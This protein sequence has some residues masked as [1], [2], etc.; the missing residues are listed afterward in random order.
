MRL[1]SERSQLLMRLSACREAT[2]SFSCTGDRSSADAAQPLTQA[3]HE[4]TLEPL[5]AGAM[6]PVCLAAVPPGPLPDM[7][8]CSTRSGALKVTFNCHSHAG[9]AAPT[10]WTGSETHPA[11]SA[12]TSPKAQLNPTHAQDHLQPPARAGAAA[13]GPWAASPRSTRQALTPSTQPDSTP[14]MRR[15]TFTLRAGAAASEPWTASDS[16]RFPSASPSPQFTPHAEL[17]SHAQDHLQPAVRARSAKAEPWA[18]THP[19]GPAAQPALAHPQP[20]QRARPGS[21]W[22]R[23]CGPVPSPG[24]R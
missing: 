8:G 9:A 12:S 20:Q 11:S 18:A 16:T 2:G 13:L 3:L 21:G 5:R 17:L 24:S 14:P 4:H 22:G 7:A 1:L 10:S 23:R 19:G 15:I 6:A